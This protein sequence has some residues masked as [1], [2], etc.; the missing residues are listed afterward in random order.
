MNPD[1]LT[2]LKKSTSEEMA[3]IGLSERFIDEMV[4]AAMRTNYGQ[5]ISIGGF[6]G[7]G[8]LIFCKTCRGSHLNVL[9]AFA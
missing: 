6:V 4:R 1:F 5:D 2:S 9:T 7:M 3:E 8:E